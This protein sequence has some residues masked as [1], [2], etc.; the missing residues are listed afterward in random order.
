MAAVR[1]GGVMRLVQTSLST[2]RVDGDLTD[3]LEWLSNRDYAIGDPRFSSEYARM[4]KGA[5]EIVIFQSGSVRL[6]GDVAA[7]RAV[8]IEAI[9][10]GG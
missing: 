7:G 1:G 8:L 2:F 3:L 6:A 5:S 9:D 4:S 10:A